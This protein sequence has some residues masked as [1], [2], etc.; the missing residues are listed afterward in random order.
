MTQ[1]LSVPVMG[2]DGCERIVESALSE[3]AGVTGVT[4][5]QLDGTATIEG[6][7]ETETLVRS[8]E[9]AGYDADVA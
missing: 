6:D 4:A 2:C 8:L 7:V 9:L 5:D 3:V 1:T